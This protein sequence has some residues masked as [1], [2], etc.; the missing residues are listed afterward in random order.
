MQRPLPT[1]PRDAYPLRWGAVRRLMQERKLDL[2]L[3][4]GD[5][6][7]V[8]GPAHIRWLADVPVHFEPFCVLFAQDEQPVLLCGPESDEY[9]R[10][11]GHIPDVRV[12]R[13][14]TH[15]DEDY[16]FTR[17]QSLVE[18]LSELG[19][20]ANNMRRVGIGGKGLMNAETLSAIME[21][22]PNAQWLDVELD[23][24]RLRAVK[25]AEELDV[26]RYAYHIA[27]MGLQAAL[28]TI[29][30]GVSERK[31]AA[32]IESA[33]RSAGAEGTGIDTIVASGT[34][35]RPILARSTFRSIEAR[36]TVLL[37]IAP[38]YEGYH[39]A[40]GRLV[41]VGQPEAQIEH[42]YHTAVEAQQ[43]CQAHLKPG[44]EGRSV[45][46]VGRDIMTAAGYGDYFLY[47]G[48]HSLGVIEFEAPIFGPS[49]PELLKEDMVI[50]IDIPAFNAPWGG[51]RV[52]DGYR[53]T[54]TACEKL[55]QTEFFFYQ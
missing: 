32:A 53:I 3:A 28:D 18:I 38:R 51:L 39:A 2:L 23:L 16:P 27:E 26:I 25:T 4:Y 11:R 33:M 48:L 5:D 31:V 30:P 17:I 13:E 42:A 9:A 24:C 20:K 34:N 47:S 40:I 29:H 12:L 45:E 49:S 41:F 8:F 46:A 6:R 44:V 50:S 54:P 15:P 1:I 21:A 22:L 37:T 19:W 35:K 55:N 7:A 43:A 52:E 10:L 14:F 36:D